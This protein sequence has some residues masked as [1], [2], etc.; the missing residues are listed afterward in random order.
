MKR[1]TILPIVFAAVF[2]LVTLPAFA[3]RGKSGG[4]G[5]P[6]G[7]PPSTPGSTHSESS[8]NSTKPSTTTPSG[9][10][11]VNEHLAHNEHLATKL[12][13]LLGL[14]GPNALSTLQ[15]KAQGFK[16]LGQ[17]VAAVHVSHN[18]DIPFDQLKAKVTAGESLGDAIHDLKPDVNPKNEVKKAQ[19]EAQEDLKESETKL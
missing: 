17:F 18:L 7:G 16:N 4:T 15:T 9:K 3:Q 6:G 1:A 8:A 2:S 19:R 5:H 13:G 12:E 11:S 14:S 10:V